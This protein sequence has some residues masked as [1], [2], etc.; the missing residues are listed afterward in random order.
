MLQTHHRVL[1]ASHTPLSASCFTHITECLMLHT[2]HRVLNASDTGGLMLQTQHKV[3]NA[4]DT[5]QSA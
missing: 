3:L 1:N 2:H 4:S 5:T